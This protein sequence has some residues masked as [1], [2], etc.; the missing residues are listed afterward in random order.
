MRL[1]LST[2]RQRR[3][4]LPLTLWGIAAKCC[5]SLKVAQ[6]LV[7]FVFNHLVIKG[8]CHIIW[9]RQTSLPGKWS[10][11]NTVLKDLVFLGGAVKTYSTHC[12]SLLNV[13]IELYFKMLYSF[14]LICFGCL[15][16]MWG[17]NLANSWHLSLS[18]WKSY[19]VKLSGLNKTTYQSSMKS[20][21]CLLEV[22]PRLG[23]RDLAVQF[24]CVEAVNTASR[25]LQR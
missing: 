6:T 22:N 7:A 2:H 19:F 15:N 11:N 14:S 16:K 21:E 13:A 9:K 18:S 24:C 12:T 20:L 3:I 10:Q 4:E 8:P 17:R 25:I 1:W 5:S 23:M